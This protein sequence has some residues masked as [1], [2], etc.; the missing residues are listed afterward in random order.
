MI[1]DTQI[2]IP[3][4]GS[5]CTWASPAQQKAEKKCN[6]L[7]KNSS[8]E[9]KHQDTRSKTVKQAYA[10]R[11]F[12]FLQGTRS[13]TRCSCC[14]ISQPAQLLFIDTRILK[15]GKPQTVF[16]VL[17]RPCY[18]TA[19]HQAIPVPNAN[20]PYKIFQGNQSLCLLGRG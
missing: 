8:A 17:L 19:E 12:A 3:P 4:T 11:A 16:S 13:Q 18:L 7:H 2:S 15:T 9:A 6:L 5:H 20:G 14:T 1:S 10:Q